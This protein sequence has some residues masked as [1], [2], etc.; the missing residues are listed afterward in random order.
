MKRRWFIAPWLVMLVGTAF[1]VFLAFSAGTQKARASTQNYGPKEAEVTLEDG[2]KTV[3]LTSSKFM[4]QLDLT[5]GKYYFR[6]D[7]HP[8]TMKGTLTVS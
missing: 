6:C 3:H 8:T 2:I 5:L 7:A 4:W 1:V